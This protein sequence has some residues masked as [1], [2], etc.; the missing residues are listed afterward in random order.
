[1]NYRIFPPRSRKSVRVE[2]PLSKSISNRA[3]IISALAGDVSS[4]GKTAECDDTDVML[5]ALQ[6]TA[7]EINIGASGTAMR[8]LTAYFAAS[9][10]KKVL[11]DGSERMRERPIVPL[12]DA[13]R[14]LGATVE[15][16]G[17]VGYPPLI[18]KGS[19]LAGGE[20]EMPASVSSQFLS[21]LLMIAPYME[22]GLILKL[23]GNPVSMPYIIMTVMMMI[24]AGVP[25]MFSDNTISVTP[26]KYAPYT[27]PAEGDWTSASYHYEAVAL[28]VADNI[29]F[30]NLVQRSLQ[31]D[32]SIARIFARFGVGTNYCGDGDVVIVKENRPVGAIDL[33]LSDNPDL[34]QT[35]AVT[36]A[37]LSMPFRITGLSTLPSK[38]T[39]RLAALEAELHKL[40]VR[41]KAEH[42][43]TLTWDGSTG[44][45]SNPVSISTYNDHRMAMAFA[46]A[47]VKH[48][49]IIIEDV[50]VV[51]KSYPGYWDHLRET[52]FKIEEC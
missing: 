46:P 49:G 3:L 25:V 5:N 20:V 45:P 42:G 9:E 28:G 30:T 8:F 47:A 41:A 32:S 39:D 21:A 38:E 24:R 22:N 36:A 16:A 44:I 17:K 7:D 33:D 35:V 19:H 40:G 2:L 27:V 6:S 34:A 10:G 11:L 23:K 14:R 15:Y 26:G 29:M 48:P 12:V 51:S 50:E 52:G 18:I 1:M 4:V 31:G 43:D 37:L 13:L